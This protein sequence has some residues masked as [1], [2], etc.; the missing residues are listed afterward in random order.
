MLSLSLLGQRLLHS[1]SVWWMQ[2]LSFLPHPSTRNPS[3]PCISMLLSLQLVSVVLPIVALVLS[4]CGLPVSNSK[5]IPLWTW[6]CGL[7]SLRLVF[8]PH[9]H[10]PRAFGGTS[11]S[12]WVGLPA[13]LGQLNFQFVKI[14]L[15]PSFQLDSDKQIFKN[16]LICGRRVLGIWAVKGKAPTTF[17]KSPSSL[18]GLTLIRH[19][20][21]SK[22]VF[23]GFLSA[24]S[25]QISSVEASPK[26]PGA[27][28]AGR[29]CYQKV[30]F[31]SALKWSR[32]EEGD[33]L[34]V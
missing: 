33:H 6:P 13:T 9:D 27:V 5:R 20:G 31:S 7:W 34:W 18:V 28:E 1:S 4:A 11:C 22:S 17:L 3:N 23:P 24:L 21:F 25:S 2:L 32:K 29:F 15:G 26:R 16:S 12:S 14:F 10:L 8:E 19:L 30:L